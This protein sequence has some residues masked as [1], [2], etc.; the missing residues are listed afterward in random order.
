[1]V[2]TKTLVCLANSRKHSGRCIAGKEYANGAFGAWV[3]PISARP[4]QEIS[5]EDRRYEDG[6]TASVLDIITIPMDRPE[7]SGYQT[8]NEV[9]DSEQYWVKEGAVTWNDLA[10]AIDAAPLPLWSDCD[11]SF[12]G[13]R[14]RVPLATASRLTN[15]L[16]LV[17]P[18]NL[19][20]S[21]ASEGGLYAPAKRKV[22][23]KFQLGGTEFWL[24]VTD[25]QAE[26]KYL[27][28]GIGTYDVGEALL[29]ISLGEP[30]DGYA[31]KLVAT[32]I[33]QTEV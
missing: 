21:V 12:Y 19:Q 15:S 4:G 30:W 33:T 7:P 14:D 25:P 16:L 28:M 3:R 5:E 18:S 10:G 29:C 24:S 2:Y 11:N 13:L 32:L 31:Y 26:S 17:R 1:M 20:M 27:G 8:E 23:A 9:I 6:T 22:R